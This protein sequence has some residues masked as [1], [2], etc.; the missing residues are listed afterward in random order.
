M[1]CRGGRSCCVR[2][3]VLASFFGF[4][5]SAGGVSLPWSSLMVL[6]GICSPWSVVGCVS[7][8]M[9]CAEPDHSS[10]TADDSAAK[11]SLDMSIPPG[12]GL[13]TQG[14]F[15]TGLARAAIGVHHDKPHLPYLRSLQ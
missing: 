8:R 10:K 14:Q 4:F 9:A 5:G 13:S 11:V 1:A 6:L 2:S 12:F 3:G 7:R 15:E